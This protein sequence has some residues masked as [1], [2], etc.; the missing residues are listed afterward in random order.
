MMV[1]KYSTEKAYL[2]CDFLNEKITMTTRYSNISGVKKPIEKRC[3][4][5]EKCTNREFCQYGKI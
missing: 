2:F 1:A 4:K 3:N 5:W